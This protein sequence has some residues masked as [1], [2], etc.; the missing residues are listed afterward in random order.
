MGFL[1][2]AIEQAS[3]ATPGEI[4]YRLARQALLAQ[5]RA[6]RLARHEVCDA[7]PELRRAARE[8]GRPT[9]A[10][11]PVCED[12]QLVHVSYVFGPRLPAHGRCVTSAAELAK[13][14]RR[15]GQFSCYVVEVCP[16]CAW[17]HLARTFLLA[18]AS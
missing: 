3:R 9:D 14:A 1:P 15:R 17:N 8:V 16:S 7:H 6:G 13:L 10:E 11:C 18:P 12:D 5:Y 4:D 2:G